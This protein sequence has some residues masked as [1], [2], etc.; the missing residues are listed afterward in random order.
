MARK[1]KRLVVT[2]TERWIFVFDDK[3]DAPVTPPPAG[4]PAPVPPSSLL[5]A[6]PSVLLVKG[7]DVVA[8][9]HIRTPSD[10]TP[11]VDDAV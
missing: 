5:D 7:A 4:S 1:R 10:I 3:D 8:S 6:D 9:T 11:T 2:V